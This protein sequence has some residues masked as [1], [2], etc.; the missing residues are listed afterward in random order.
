MERKRRGQRERLRRRRWKWRRMEEREEDKGGGRP[1]RRRRSAL[2][3]LPVFCALVVYGTRGAPPRGLNLRLEW[4]T[5][6]RSWK[7]EEERAPPGVGNSPGRGEK[8][9]RRRSYHQTARERERERGW[10]NGG[11]GRRGLVSFPSVCRLHARGL[12]AKAKYPY[13]ISAVH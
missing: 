5:D 10:R 13:R 3:P 1:R 4:R 8:R 6:G 2:F 7:E 11:G 9:R 12:A